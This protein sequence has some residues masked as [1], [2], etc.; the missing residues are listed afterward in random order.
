MW[1]IPWKH[2]TPRMLD[3]EDLRIFEFLYRFRKSQKKTP[4]PQDVGFWGFKDI[5]VLF[6]N[7]KISESIT[8]S[9]C[10][11]LRIWGFFRSYPDLV[12][13]LKTWHPQDVGY[14]G[15]KDI[16]V[17]VQ[18]Q[19]ISE[20]TTHSGCWILRIWGYLSSFQESENFWIHHTPRI[21][22]IKDLRIF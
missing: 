19:K 16:Q 4:H 3:I 15:F 21:L 7:Q 2:N 12:N 9:G 18:I 10:W 11:I 8:P 14:W 6:K 17:L 13:S 5:W 20:N 1:S 22:D